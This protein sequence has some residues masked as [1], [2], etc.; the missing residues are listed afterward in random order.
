MECTGKTVN[1]LQTSQK[2]SQCQSTREKESPN[3]ETHA[4]TEEAL[5]EFNREGGLD[6]GKQVYSQG[7]KAPKRGGR[8]M[9]L[10]GYQIWD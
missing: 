5:D 6:C 1:N 4:E 2:R 10:G 7:A 8:G 3:L 9:S